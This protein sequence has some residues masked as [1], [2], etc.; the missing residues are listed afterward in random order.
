M[1]R[2]PV[3]S[4][5]E[6]S[7]GVVIVVIVV[8]NDEL[9]Y[10]LRLFPISQPHWCFFHTNGGAANL[11]P[12]R[13][14]DNNSRRC[15]RHRLKTPWADGSREGEVAR[16]IGKEMLELETAAAGAIGGGWALQ[17]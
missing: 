5:I 11:I 13:F 3:D 8:I 1:K 12:R 15:V 10:H 9:K 2:E 14:D 16:A 17:L 7:S 4:L 6:P